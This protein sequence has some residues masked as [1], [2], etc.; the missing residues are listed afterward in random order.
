MAS[1]PRPAFVPQPPSRILRDNFGRTPLRSDRGPVRNRLAASQERQALIC[2]MIS[3][4]LPAA[5][6]K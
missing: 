4:M 1:P 5:A 6:Y 2:T 3:Y